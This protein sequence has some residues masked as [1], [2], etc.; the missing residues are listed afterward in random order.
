MSGT[1]IYWVPDG[2]NRLR[3]LRLTVCSSEDGEGG[4]TAS[5]RRKMLTRILREASG[6]GGSLSY[7]DLCMIML[8]SKATIKRD[9]SHLRRMGLEMPVG[10]KA[11]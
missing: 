9:I 5:R 7:R 6:Q 3:Q 10:H 1:L 2:E 4:G 11:A 8:A